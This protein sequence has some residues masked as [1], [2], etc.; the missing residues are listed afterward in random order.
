MVGI[1]LRNG[2]GI[3][4]SNDYTVNTF[5][6]VIP[7]E[8]SKGNSTVEESQNKSIDKKKQPDY[9]PVIGNSN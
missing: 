7:E 6:Q 8:N 2:E 9:L 4:A 5:N 3:T 1:P